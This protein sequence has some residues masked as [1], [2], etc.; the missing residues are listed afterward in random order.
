MFIHIGGMG[1]LTSLAK[2]LRLAL[3]KTAT[4]KSAAAANPEPPLALDT[5]LIEKIIGHLGQAN[6]EAF[7]I[8]LGREGVKM[9]GVQVTSSMGLNSWAGF[10]GT[11]DKAHVA[12]DIVMTVKEVNPVIQTLRKGGIYVVAVHNHML[13]EEPRVF[14]LH[15]WG[16][17]PSE[18]LAHTVR[19]AFDLV[20]GPVR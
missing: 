1:S 19:A 8:T 7:K 11:D 2:G 20:K 4:P 15:Y 17:G 10:V 16:T 3:E 9:E 14:F 18:A 13:T 6:G 5:K 12:G